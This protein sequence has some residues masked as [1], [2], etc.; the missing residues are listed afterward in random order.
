MVIQV[1]HKAESRVM[2]KENTLG[3]EAKQELQKLIK[4]LFLAKK[5]NAHTLKTWIHEC[6]QSMKFELDCL[7]RSYHK[8]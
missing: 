6:L 1:L 5:M 7:E 8:Q 3:V 2:K 4:S